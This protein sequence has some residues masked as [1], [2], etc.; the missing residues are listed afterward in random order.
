[1]TPKRLFAFLAIALLPA[2]SFATVTPHPLFSDG[3]I[4]QRNKPVT[5]WG[6]ADDGENVTVKIQGQE[7][8]A[9]AKGGKWMVTLKPLQAGG[10]FTMTITGDTPKDAA[11]PIEVKNVLVGEVWVCSGQSNMQF[12]LAGST[13]GK[14]AIA[15]STDPMLRLF[16]VPRKGAQSELT[17]ITSKDF[18][19]KA[20]REKWNEAKPETVPGFSAVAYYFGRDLRR[21]LNVPVGLIHTS[22]GGTYAEAWTRRPRSNQNPSSPRS[23]RPTTAPWPPILSSWSAT[24]RRSKNTRQPSPKQKPRARK[25]PPRHALPTA[26]THRTGPPFFTTR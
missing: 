22:Y 9:S 24:S 23:S 18:P 19:L 14:D 25:H 11:T 12:T 1:M 10:P 2:P 20:G 5:V 6:V 16:S 8:L 15:G 26:R 21:A 17:D 4:L 3:A 13:D 7:V